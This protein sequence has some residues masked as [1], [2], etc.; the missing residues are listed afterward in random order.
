MLL[1]EFNEEISKLKD[2][3]PEDFLKIEKLSNDIKSK[4]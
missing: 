1:N 2:Q 4:F 3:I